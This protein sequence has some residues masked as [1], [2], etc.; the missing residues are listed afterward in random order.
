MNEKIPFFWHEMKLAKMDH[1]I[2]KLW[3]LAIVLFTAFTA[4][5]IGCML[6]FFWLR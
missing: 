2:K 4:S 3:V 5:N 6:R 1:R